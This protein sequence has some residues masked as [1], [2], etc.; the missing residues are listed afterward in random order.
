M[1]QLIFVLLFAV[2]YKGSSAQ[3]Q[4]NILY[5]IKRWFPQYGKFLPVL[6]SRLLINDTLSYEYPFDGKDDVKPPYGKKFRWHSTYKNIPS[7]LM[8]SQSEP[9][10]K[11]RFLIFDTIP[12]I[13]WELVDEEKSILK[14]NCKKATC[15]YR[16][17]I[18][19]A[20]YTKDIPLA[21][22]YDIFGGLPGLILEM[23]SPKGRQIITA[24]A[25][26]AE[27]VEI[28]QPALGKKITPE[29]FQKVLKK[30]HKSHPTPIP[31]VRHF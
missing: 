17:V 12:K 15:V 9:R 8:L 18:Y 29:Q 2:M 20:W 1:K 26:T 22:G 3:K 5:E 24:T 11:P 28:V 10:D 7:N 30:L 16:N 19:I 31:T 23:V 25:I 14:Y 13:Q 27:S 6:H 21:F 4:Y